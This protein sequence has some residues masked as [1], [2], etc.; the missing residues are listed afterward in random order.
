[1]LR[2]S[3][4]SKLEG[5]LIAAC[6]ILC[7]IC[8]LVF[9]AWL[10]EGIHLAIVAGKVSMLLEMEES[11]RDSNSPGEA[12]HAAVKALEMMPIRATASAD[13]ILALVASNTVHHLCSL[14]RQQTGTDFGDHPAEWMNYVSTNAPRSP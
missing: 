13:I 5:T 4:L 3:H 11:A 6:F 14:L 1:M 2:F 10:R 7:A 8:A 9:S 12:A